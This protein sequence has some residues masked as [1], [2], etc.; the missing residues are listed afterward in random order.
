[1]S[2]QTDV[3]QQLNLAPVLEIFSTEHISISALVTVGSEIAEQM[4]EGVGSLGEHLR[5]IEPGTYTIGEIKNDATA[6]TVKIAALAHDLPSTLRG[7]RVTQASDGAL[8]SFA[9]FADQTH[10]D[11]IPMDFDVLN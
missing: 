7:I 6:F 2:Q 5:T 8:V 3:E 10:G 11:M 4:L 1:M 9:L